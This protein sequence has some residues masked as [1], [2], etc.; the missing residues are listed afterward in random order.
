[1]AD[2]TGC[3]GTGILDLM[4]T[5]SYDNICTVSRL[6]P[7]HLI[8]GSDDYVVPVSSSTC[9]GDALWR[10]GASVVTATV[11]S[12]CSHYDIC[13]DLME[14]GRFWHDVVMNEIHA[15]FRQHVHTD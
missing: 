2:S 12:G 11:V 1:V 13:V 7:I 5:E 3:D 4:L 6:P 15:V 8:H 9:F 14:N 10:R